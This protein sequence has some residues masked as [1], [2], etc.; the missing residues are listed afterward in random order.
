MGTRRKRPGRSIRVLVMALLAA[1]ALLA[2]F[3]GTAGAARPGDSTTN[4]PAASTTGFADDGCYYDAK[5]VRLG[6]LVVTDGELTYRV[7]ATGEVFHVA[8]G[9][10]GQP[11]LDPVASNRTNEQTFATGCYNDSAGKGMYFYFDGAVWYIAMTSQTTPWLTLA[12]YDAR[13]GSLGNFAVDQ[14][15]CLAG[16]Y[17]NHGQTLQFDGTAW[18][19]LSNGQWVPYQGVG[20]EEPQTGNGNAGDTTA[21]PGENPPDVIP[22]SNGTD[23]GPP[24]TDSTGTNTTGTGETG[25]NGQLSDVRQTQMDAWNMCVDNYMNAIV[26]DMPLGGTISQACPIPG[27]PENPWLGE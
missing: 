27:S 17:P 4:Q 13:F 14:V 23:G 2:G 1:T 26:L 19:I 6:C 18:F 11:R 8:I 10:D 25:N 16:Q 24:V 22:T 3:G 5:G 12:E 15:Y 21:A 20:A 7:E 9:P